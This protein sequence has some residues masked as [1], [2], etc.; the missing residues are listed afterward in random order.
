MH[1]EAGWI[2]WAPSRIIREPAFWKIGFAFAM[3][4]MG[5]AG[6][7]SQLKPRFSDLG[8]DDRT[9]MIM[10]GSTAFLGAIGK[11]AWGALCDHMEARRVVATLMGLTC[12][13]MGF[14]FFHQSLIALVMFII[15]FGFAMGGVMSTLPIIVAD[16][17]GRESFAAV[18]RFLSLFMLIGMP[19]FIIASLSADLTGSY[20]AAYGLFM[21]LDI[22]AAC[23]IFT[24]KRPVMRDQGSKVGG[25]KRH[26]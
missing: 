1:S 11:F 8:F 25:Q 9:A 26:M 14:S 13:G 10:M 22:I 7:M 17:F 23:L 16:I 3:V 12:L 19:G 21:A 24:V 6:V 4:T 20:D 15:I 2:H 5:L 18:S